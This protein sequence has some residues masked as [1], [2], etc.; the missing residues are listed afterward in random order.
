MMEPFAFGALLR[1]KSRRTQ[2]AP[3]LRFA[4]RG[5]L[6]D[7]GDGK[8]QCACSGRCSLEAHSPNLR[9][10]QAVSYALSFFPG[11]SVQD[12]LVGRLRR[13]RPSA[14]IPLAPLGD[15]V[16]NG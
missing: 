4:T 11:L 16:A 2:R 14:G 3:R 9:Q 7:A 6:P 10:S 13:P 5:E 12:R 1:N 8:R 15:D